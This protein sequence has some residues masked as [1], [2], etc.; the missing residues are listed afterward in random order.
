MPR[1]NDIIHNF[2]NGEVSP[3]LY[4]RTDSEIYKRSCREVKNM[5]IYPQ[6][7]ASRRVGTENVAD[8]L[9][10]LAFTRPLERGRLIPFIFSRTES[11]L[12]YFEGLSF[13]PSLGQVFIARIYNIQENRWIQVTFDP[14]VF[15]INAN[16][17][18]SGISTKASDPRVIQEIQYAQKGDLMFFA[19]AELPPFV[20]ARTGLNEFRFTD[21]HVFKEG[22]GGFRDTI[23]ATAPN[24]GSITMTLSSSAVGSR[25]MTA[26]SD[27][28]ASNH[29][30]SWFFFQDGGNVGYGLITAVASATSATILIRQ[31]APAAFSSGGAAS[32]GEGAWSPRRG[33]PRTVTFW[34]NRSMWGGTRAEPDTIWSSSLGDV[35][36]MSSKAVIDPGTD[37]TAAGPQ[38]F[39]ISSTEANEIQWMRGGNNLLAG[40]RGREYFI[41]SFTLDDVSVRPQTGF[42][43]EY[44]QPAVVDDSPVFVQRGFRKMREMR[45]DYR[46]EG[47][48][49]SDITLLAEHFP[50][51]SERIMQTT[52][53]SSIKQIAYQPLDNNI[54]WV[55]D[56]NGYLFAITR[57][58]EN[59]VL[60][61]H[62][63]ELGGRLGDDIPKVLSVAA[64]PNKEG[65]SEDV[66]LLVKRTVNDQDIIRIEK[67][68]SDFYGSEL[69]PDTDDKRLIP[70]FTDSAKV[71]RSFPQAKFFA[72]LGD[73]LD[74]DEGG[75][76]LTGTAGGA[77]DVSFVGQK[78]ALLNFAYITY[79][80]VDNANINKGT[81]KWTWYPDYEATG[82]HTMFSISKST[83]SSENLLQLTWDDGLIRITVQDDSSGMVTNDEILADLTQFSWGKGDYGQYNFEFCFDYGAGKS[84][85]LFL[86]GFEIGSRA[87]EA[88]RDVNDIGLLRIGGTF[89]G[90]SANSMSYVQNFSVFDEVLYT[91]SHEFY[92][93]QRLDGEVFG[94]WEFEGEEVRLFGDGNDLGAQTVEDGKVD[95][96]GMSYDTLVVGFSYEHLLEINNVEAGSAVGSSQGRPKKIETVTLRFNESAQCRFGP[97]RGRQQEIVFRDSS[98]LGNPIQLFT[99]DKILSFDGDYTPHTT[100]VISGD[101]PLP[102]NL[103]CLIARGVSYD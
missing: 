45:F 72:S 9:P 4:G 18:T 16:I 23:P 30:G 54:I 101:A 32:W 3:R 15:S 96:N 28:F 52:E 22:V 99:G 55:V 35:F 19:H 48:G 92:P 14:A 53:S 37:L 24:D 61:F 97:S 40:T 42:G 102:C 71:Y 57:D 89:T 26:S 8:Y 12:V 11:Y 62:R 17:P 20:L 58:S 7:G 73:S 39:S 10:G 98:N 82:R 95:L 59:N 67:M 36:Q 70:I 44:I 77:G 56:T 46:I 25:T 64:I 79:D 21:F 80:A 69:D 91:E 76:T 27:Y 29:V 75:G 47:Y 50:R 6:G 93:Y 65:T 86:N 43:S 31:E 51:L 83:G 74:A 60:A 68:R 33:F 78:A 100:V 38:R 66:Y 87:D 63:H 2:L 84:Q 90:S 1:F 88:T 34:D 85:K 94:L 103:T 41:S 49:A 81:I 13:D 5:K